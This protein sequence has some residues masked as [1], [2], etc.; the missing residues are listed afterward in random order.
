MHMFIMIAK[1]YSC[2][3]IICALAPCTN[4]QIRLVGGVVIHEG[5]VEVCIDNQWGTVCDD[6]WD[7]DDSTVVCRQLGFSTTGTVP[8]FRADFHPL[9]LLIVH[10]SLPDAVPFLNSQFGSAISSVPIYYDNVA[11]LGTES[12]LANCP[13]ASSVSCTHSEDAGVRCQG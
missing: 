11:C 2:N 12:Y 13:R 9:M 10:T 7:T 4:G 5:R 6:S 8:T 3:S 1:N